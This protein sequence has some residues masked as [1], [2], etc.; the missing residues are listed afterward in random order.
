MQACG[1]TRLPKEG[2][3]HATHRV[4]QQACSKHR[5]LSL[6]HIC[7]KLA[8]PFVRGGNVLDPIGG[9]GTLNPCDLYQPLENIRSGGSIQSL[10]PAML[11]YRAKCRDNFGNHECGKSFFII[12]LAHEYLSHLLYIFAI[13]HDLAKIPQG[14]ARIR[15]KGTS[16]G[17]SLIHISPSNRS[18]PR[19]SARMPT[20]PCS[21]SCSGCSRGP[22][23]GAGL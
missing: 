3:T 1:R 22:A 2:T 18:P 16:L 14:V 17:L 5:C 15:G 20:M 13:L 10:L 12:E 23:G 21:M 19:S 6:I 8:Q 11:A 7:Y 4:R 9:A